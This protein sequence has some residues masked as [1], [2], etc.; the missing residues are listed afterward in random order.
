MQPC[1]SAGT[2]QRSRESSPAVNGGE[3][4]Q[5]RASMLASRAGLYWRI[6]RDLQLHC[7]GRLLCELHVGGA[8]S[9]RAQ[10]FRGNGSRVEDWNEWTS[11]S[12]T[13]GDGNRVRRGSIQRRMLRLDSATGQALLKLADTPYVQS[14]VKHDRITHAS[15]LPRLGDC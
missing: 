2:R 3:A 14:I 12:A 7:L 9:A 5:P 6:C 15:M 11:C 13:C 1:G 8:L 10:W 4:R